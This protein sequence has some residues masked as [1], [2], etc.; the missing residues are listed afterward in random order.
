MTIPS[1]PKVMMVGDFTWPWY[2][3]ACADGLETLGCRVVRF[4]WLGDFRHWVAGNTEPVYH[5]WWH[6]LQYRFGTGPVV[7][8]ISRRL[9]QVAGAEKPDAVFFYNVTLLGPRTVRKLRRLLPDATLCQYSNDNPFSEDAKTGWWRNYL[10]SIPLFDVSFAF[11]HDNIKDYYRFGARRVELL[12]AYFIPKDE[13]PVPEAEIPERFKCD[14]VFAGHYENDGRVEFLETICEAGFRLNLFGGGWQA[15]RVR[16]RPDSPLHSHYP[17]MPA[18]GA[19]YR[20]ALCGA[21]VA[22]CFLSSL[23]RDT[24][25]RRNFQIPAMKVAMLSQYTDDL[26][27]LFRP[28]V[29]ACFF[30]DKAEMLAKIKWL[31]DDEGVR[32]A[33]AE[34]GYRRVWKDDHGVE[35]RMKILLRR[36]AEIKLN[37]P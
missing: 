17:I 12:R 2:Q 16:L 4:G 14:V 10:K 25:T 23:N 18:T 6:R 28:D 34:A 7:W 21:K 3:E 29:D 32:N 30:K 8:R 19:N 11:R 31:V 26:A 35:G 24:Y 1:S 5:S 33:I 36:L 15:A 20:H 37:S 22:L 13:Y 9:L 27:S